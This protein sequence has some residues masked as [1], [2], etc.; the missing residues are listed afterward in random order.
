MA[1]IFHRPHQEELTPW[2]R[3]E[4]RKKRAQKHHPKQ[5]DKTDNVSAEKPVTTKSKRS[6]FR[7][8]HDNKRLIKQNK[9]QQAD[10]LIAKAEKENPVIAQVQPAAKKTATE[11]EGPEQLPVTQDKKPKK[12]PRRLSQARRRALV[13]VIGFAVAVVITVISILPVSRIASVRVTGTDT[14][15]GQAIVQAS[16]LRPHQSLITVYPRMVAANHRIKQNVNSVR[17]VKVQLVGQQVILHVREYPIVGYQRKANRY[18][19]VLASG[20][21]GRTGIRRISGNYPV[22]YGFK[23]GELRVMAAQVNRLPVKVRQAISEIHAQPNRIDPQRVHLYM[24]SGNEVIARVDT[25]ASKMKYYPAI[26]AKMKAKGVVDFEVGAYSYP[27]SD[28][29]R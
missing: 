14:A 10:Q 11:T 25:F 1:S 22:F 24:N 28:K 19:K 23:P 5:A 26:A 27:F 6:P 7:R 18:Y 29:N 2:E 13:L 15:T 9:K 12:A 8:L 3:A 17:Q 16:Q 21:V 20:A 4:R